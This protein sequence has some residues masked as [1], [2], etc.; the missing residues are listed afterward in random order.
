VCKDW[1][2]IIRREFSGNYF[3][4][5]AQ[6]RNPESQMRMTRG[7]D[8]TAARAAKRSHALGVVKLLK[9]QTEQG[10]A[11]WILE[12]HRMVGER[13]SNSSVSSRRL[14]S[15]QA[16]STGNNST[17]T[18]TSSSSLTPRHLN[19]IFLWRH[20]SSLCSLKIDFPF[21]LEILKELNIFQ[22]LEK[23]K[24]LKIT[25]GA[26][27]DLRTIFQLFKRLEISELDI[28]GG[29][30]EWND[31]SR[32]KNRNIAMLPFVAINELKCGQWWDNDTACWY[33]DANMV[34]FV[35]VLL[36]QRSMRVI[37]I[38]DFP[39]VAHKSLLAEELANQPFCEEMTIKITRDEVYDHQRMLLAS[40]P[41]SAHTLVLNS[42]TDSAQQDYV[43]SLQALS[44]AF[45]DATT[46][47]LKRLHLE[48]AMGQIT[49]QLLD[50]LESLKDVSRLLVK[51]GEPQMITDIPTLKQLAF[52]SSLTLVN[53][54][55]LLSL[56]P[57]E[58][59]YLFLSLNIDGRSGS[60][61]VNSVTRFYCIQQLNVKLTDGSPRRWSSDSLK[62]G[63][64]SEAMFMVENFLVSNPVSCFSLMVAEDILAG[65][66]TVFESLHDCAE[67]EELSVDII[68]S[69][70]FSTADSMR[71]EFNL[72]GIMPNV[73]F[74]SI[75]YQHI[76][77]QQ[78]AWFALLMPR[79]EEFL[80]CNHEVTDEEMEKIIREKTS[81]R[82]FSTFE[83]FRQKHSAESP[84]HEL[85]ELF[86]REMLTELHLAVHA[87]EY[88]Q[89]HEF[90]TEEV[91]NIIE[92]NGSRTSFLF[93]PPAF[94]LL[95]VIF[96]VFVA[97]ESAAH[98]TMAGLSA[99]D[100]NPD[101]WD[102]ETD[103]MWE[104]MELEDFGR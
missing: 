83:D 49:S 74:F 54:F 61:D 44:N 68:A 86:L 29:E 72:Q 62:R 69:P 6:Y 98:A 104:I 15:S 24:T 31:T 4:E 45:Q 20:L 103:D 28:T 41:D 17:S 39:Q 50:Y 38:L 42:H 9:R 82:L 27:L 13:L 75:D 76:S 88:N 36:R 33:E 12:Y 30:F 8:S 95:Y 63:T 35:S 70:N 59:N 79:V 10:S 77:L 3:L 94:A 51:T 2:D 64:Y 22:H 91:F 21:S 66:C 43:S 89:I 67:L 53:C 37:Q 99:L 71:I 40:N 81:F 18:T 26:H 14:L 7:D 84:C 102:N 5:T 25:K 73:T 46:T 56:A 47:N 57:D 85:F 92:E 90:V 1:R 96:T 80:F 48:L 55:S 11:S 87:D 34:K 16:S 23:I 78:L 97:E 52:L 101:D 19:I 32:S 60:F 93:L 58:L 65:H 100:T